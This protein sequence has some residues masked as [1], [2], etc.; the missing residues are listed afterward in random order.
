MNVLTIQNLSKSFGKQKIIDG[1]SMSVPEGS[2]F[3][4]I[5]KNGAGKTTTMKMVLGLLQPDSGN[6]FVCNEPVRFG[7]TKTNQYIGYLPDVPEFYNYMTPINYLTLC[8]E[9]IGLSKTEITQRGQ[10]L[11]TLVGLDGVTKQIGGFSRGMKQRLGIAQALL[12]K[13]RLLICD[14]PTSALDPAGRKEILL[15]AAPLQKLRLCTNMTV[16]FWNFQLIMS[17]GFS[18]NRK[19]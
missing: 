16:C 10:E 6:I 12:T 1:L 9:V 4:F 15:S 2:V 3:G 14:E 13:P 17:C 18:G 7:Q 19:L 8:G 11:L 5:G